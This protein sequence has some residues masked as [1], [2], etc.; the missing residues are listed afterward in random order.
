MPPILQ[1][2]KIDKLIGIFIKHFVMNFQKYGYYIGARVA[3]NAC[4]S[5]EDQKSSSIR[6]I[7]LQILRC[8]D[9]RFPIGMLLPFNR[10]S[11]F[12]LSEAA[13]AGRDIIWVQNF[14]YNL[15]RKVLEAII[16]MWR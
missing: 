10:R 6:L 1:T 14:K 9:T 5:G 3:L 4:S 8:W 16:E 2:Q 15:R 11:M 13:K 12:T 7:N